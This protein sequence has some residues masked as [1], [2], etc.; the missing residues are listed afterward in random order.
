MR[1]V[2]LLLLLVVAAA[3]RAEDSPDGS[4]EALYR[5]HCAQCHDGGV[6]RAPGRAALKEMSA[7]RILSSL[8]D[9]AMSAQAQGLSP[10]DRRALSRL[11]GASA[12][13]ATT[14]AGI[15]ADRDRPLVDPVAMPHWNGWGVDTSQRRFQPAAMAQLAP[16]DVPRLKLKWAFGFPGVTRAYAQPAVMGGRIFVGSAA[17]KA[18][19][20]E[21]KTGCTYW[22]FDAGLPVRTAISLDHAAGGWVAY[23]GDVRANAY[24]VD[25]VSGKL[26]WK[27]HVHEHP[28]ATVTGA[29]V[30]ADDVLYVPVS[31]GE[32]VAGANPSYPCC[33]FRGSI[34][35]LA[36]ATGKPLWQGYTIAEPA[37]PT[38]KNERGIEL[39][40]PSGAGIWSSPTIDR[41]KRLVYATT[42]D[43]Y[44]DPPADTSDAF[45]AFELATGKLMWSRQ[46]TAG[47]AY[48]VSCSS[49]PAGANNC[50]QAKGPD[51]DFGSSAILVELAGDK[52]ALIAGQKSGMVHALDPDRNGAVLWQ[53]RVGRGTAVGGVQW[54][55]AADARYVY[56]AVSD[57]RARPA[58]EGAAGARK[59]VF[60]PT[61]QL[62]PN[63]GGGLFA[64]KLETGEIAWHTPHPG[65]HDVPGCSPAQSAAVTA[66]PE[67]VFSGSL[68]GHLRAYAVATGEIVWDADTNGDYQT[69]NGVPAH[70]GALDGPGAV[71]VGGMLYVNSGYAFLGAA[72]GNVLL[73]FS[74]DGK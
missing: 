49:S 28:T 73:A 17:G 39:L 38:R 61:F 7:E 43:S 65:C 72:P 47:D 20:L 21:A 41:A 9:G 40:G 10:A 57:L 27:T 8:S 44:S 23:F 36:A 31:S 64:L 37:R 1:C 48:T 62:D 13:A 26:L 50:P 52:R 25:A 11:L 56:V 29:P 58:P 71:V 12:P 66:I 63:V 51:F 68:D 19:S 42:G 32:E 74:V 24:A 34:A 46:M 5:E 14:D 55:A 4:A 22:S 16:E 2:V 59:S 70:G 54:G 60:G 30:L 3:A 69:V 15:C 67:V 33:S 45:V 6:E 53:T 35:A 18:Y